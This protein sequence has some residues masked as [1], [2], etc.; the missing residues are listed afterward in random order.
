MSVFLLVASF[1]CASHLSLARVAL[2]A[3]NAD[4]VE[5]AVQLADYGGDLLGQVARVHCD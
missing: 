1:V 2:M 4:L 3:G 5:Q